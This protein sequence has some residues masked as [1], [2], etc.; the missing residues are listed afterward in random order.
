MP[1]LAPLPEGFAR[2]RDAL[3][4]VAFFA[5][6]P[7][8]Y[9]AMGRLGLRAIGRGFGTPEFGEKERVLVEGAE[10]VWRRAG[11]DARQPLSTVENAAAFLDIPYQEVWFAD[12]HDPPAPLAPSAPLDVSEG[13][14]LALGDWFRFTT[15]VLEEARAT[16]GAVDVS[17]VQL[18]PEHFDPAFEMGSQ[19]D[20]RRASYGGSPGDGNHP[21][22]YLY[23][24]AWG[25]IDRTD[26]YWNDPHF[27]GSSL[28]YAELLASSDPVAAGVEFL[29]EGYRVLSS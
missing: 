3:H 10:L 8:R 7:K 24:S 27:N 23:V 2:T 6:A 11:A 28:G 5:V 12:F 21:E 20:G 19:D 26:P 25:E 1:D 14:S 9:R 16:P 29:L 4:Q 18:W 15:E 13:A 17:E 22:P